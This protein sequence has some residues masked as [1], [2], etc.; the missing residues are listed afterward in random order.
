VDLRGLSPVGAACCCE[1]GNKPSRFLE[2]ST[3]LGKIGCKEGL[4][5]MQSDNDDVII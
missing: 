4:S 1:H 5:Y 3:S 2:G